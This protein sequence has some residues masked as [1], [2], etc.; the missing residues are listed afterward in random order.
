MVQ[1]PLPHLPTIKNIYA[2]LGTQL[3]ETIILAA[4]VT[5]VIIQGDHILKIPSELLLMSHLFCSLAFS[6]A[7]NGGVVW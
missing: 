7:L 5:N 2:D 4:V 3:A 1:A 6:L